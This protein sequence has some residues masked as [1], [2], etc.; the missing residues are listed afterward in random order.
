MNKNFVDR[1]KVER[2]K[3]SN[4]GNLKLKGTNKEIKVWIKDFSLYG[5]GIRFFKGYYCGNCPIVQSLLSKTNACANCELESYEKFVDIIKEGK[6][7]LPVN[8]INNNEYVNYK[9][10]WWC[11][12]KSN[13]ELEFGV[14]F[15]YE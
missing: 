7:S 6:V 9:M 13:D 8:N 12:V 11:N 4:E 3:I 15:V 14:E 10:K 5:M 2:I 1:R